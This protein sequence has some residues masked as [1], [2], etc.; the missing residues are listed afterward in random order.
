VKTVFTLTGGHIAP[1]LVGCEE[2]GIRVV[3]VR[4]EVSAAFAADAISRTTGIPGVAIV[5]A[6]PGLSNTITAVKNAQMAQS[7]LILI[8]GATSDLLKGR[9]SL[10]DIDQ[11]AL[12]APHTKWMGHVSRVADIVPLLEEA[13]YRARE[14]VPGPVFVEFPLDTL[15][16]KET[17]KW[18]FE[19]DKPKGGGLVNKAI[20][21]YIDRHFSNLFSETKRIQLH[22]PI[23]VPLAIAAGWQVSQAAKMISS[24]KKIVMIIGAQAVMVPELTKGLVDAVNTIGA[25]VWLSSCGRGLLGAS[26]PLQFRHK[27]GDAIKEADLVVLAGV[28]MDFRL[29]YGMTIRGKTKIISINLDKNDLFKNRTPTLAILA[30]PAKGLGQIGEALRAAKHDSNQFVSW[31]SD[32]RA[33]EEKREEAITVMAQEK[34][35]LINPVHL[36]AELEKFI[37]PDAVIVADGGDIVGTFA[38]NVRPRGPRKWLDPGAFG[39]LGVGGGFALGAGCANPGTELWIIWGDGACGFS[40]A[41]F[42]TLVRHKIPVIAVVGNDACWTQIVRDQVPLLGK[43]TAGMLTYADYHLVAKGFGAEG[44]LINKAE[45]IE[46]GFAL[47]KKYFHEG[48]AVLVNCLL[49]QSKFREGSIS[50]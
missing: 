17:A 4:H 31:V 47:A 7:P 27:R 19:K 21:W 46:E 20:C 25:P 33:R 23:P 44:I 50:M 38:Y 36:C 37:A 9:G 29:G 42:D 43:A 2:L 13:F 49:G 30:D 39:T 11:F 26:H 24:A 35:D 40:I 22:K 6:G 5:T 1:I 32:V 14:G 3:D 28:V 48:K 45:D 41:E 15:Y 16:R 18:V 10:Q 34:N 8:G 12:L